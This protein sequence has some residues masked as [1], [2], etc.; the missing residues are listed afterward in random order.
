MTLLFFIGVGWLVYVFAGYPVLLAVIASM[1][2]VRPKTRAGFHPSVSVLISARNEEKDIGWKISETLKWEYPAEQIEILVAS[3]AS[4]D[5]TDAII[6]SIKDSRITFLRIEN[7]GGKGRALN[8]LIKKARGEI[9]FF[10]DA[11]AHI[12]PECLNSMVGHFADERVGCV[13]GD[14]Y[15]IE[16]DCRSEHLD[17]GFCMSRMGRYSSGTQTRHTRS[18]LEGDAFVRREP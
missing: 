1:Y 12:G 7:R 5:R 8:R 2:R 10:T 4:E 13:T 14:S 11:N 6:Q 9:L 16:A 15:S 3:D 17:I 18:L